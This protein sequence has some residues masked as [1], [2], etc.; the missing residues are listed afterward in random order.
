MRYLSQK[1]SELYVKRNIINPDHKEVYRSGVEL[2]LNEVFTFLLV[3]LISLF[4]TKFRYSVEF[5]ATFCLT[6]IYCGGFH[7]KTVFVCRTT[8]ITMFLTVVVI[9]Y[10]VDRVSIVAIGAVL[11]VFFL[12]ML[13][14]IPVKHPNKTLT[15][16]QIVRNRIRGIFLYLLFSAISI[17]VYLFLS[18]QDGF[19]ICLSLCAVSALTIVGT[20]VNNRR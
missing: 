14:F 16:E 20:I 17:G 7:A 4:F 1:I 6:R 18:K 9:S 10:Y 15:K 19:V 8:M 3:L 5:L 12:I 2:I 13:P 11:A